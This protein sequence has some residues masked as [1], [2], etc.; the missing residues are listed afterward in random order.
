MS[1]NIDARYL[2]ATSPEVSRNCS[3]AIWRFRDLVPEYADAIPF[4]EIM[5]S[6]ISLDQFEAS[7][8]GRYNTR[9][10]PPQAYTDAAF[11]QFE[12][13][14]VWRKEWFSVGRLEEIPN[15]GDYFSVDVCGEPIIVVRSSDHE[16]TAM[17]AVCQHRAMLVAEGKGNCRAFVC[18]YHRW[19][20]NLQGRLTGAPQMA[21]VTIFDRSEISLPKVAVDIWQGIIFVNFDLKARP[22]AERLSMLD[23][24]V[25]PWR[26]PELKGDFLK[27]P[28]YKQYHDYN[29]NWKIYMEG[30]AECYHCD[31]LHG[32][33]PGIMNIDCS[34]QD[35][36]VVDVTNGVF[37]FLMQSK[38]VDTTINH[39][40]QAI[41]PHI[42][43]L[44]EAQRFEQRS[45]I[46]APNIFL[47][48]MPDCVILLSWWPTG[49][50]SMR[51]KRHR[52]HPQETLDRDDFVARHKEE[53]VAIR[54]FVG[55]DDYA[56]ERVQTGLRS[57]FAP[58]GPLSGTEF[59]INGLNNWL[60]QRYRGADA[61]FRRAQA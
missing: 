38:V 25:A 55:Q 48:L 54:Y 33:T 53:S 11:H 15:K 16:I 4:G 27:D 30:Q 21:G 42:P 34:K 56:F 40:G 49:P 46:I 52:L 47:Q 19:T 14:A 58:R 28:N 60:I 26:L 36:V 57:R 39:V 12:L 6:P 23:L 45:F 43:G 51:V 59:V 22:I 13:E 35:V 18:P 61:M 29:W 7:A 9:F 2:T 31:K 17:S 20:Y 3:A 24:I 10:L 32:D 5:L 50:S 41:F 44:T 37:S 8:Q 1:G